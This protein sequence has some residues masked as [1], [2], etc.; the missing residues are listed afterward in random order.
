[1]GRGKLCGRQLQTLDTAKHGNS[2]SEPRTGMSARYVDRRHVPADL[3]FV[4]LEKKV[5]P[6]HSQPDSL[7]EN[8]DVNQILIQTQK[9][10][11]AKSHHSHHY[12]LFHNHRPGDRDPIK[13]QTEMIIQDAKEAPMCTRRGMH[14]MLLQCWFRPS[15]ARNPR[16]VHE[17]SL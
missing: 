16:P 4:C 15:R 11:H 7:P 2:T 8:C 17:V 12:H 10:P 14:P 1:M 13:K 9:S 6:I 3:S 5:T